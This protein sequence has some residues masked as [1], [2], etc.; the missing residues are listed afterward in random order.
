MARAVRTTSTVRAPEKA[1]ASVRY[2]SWLLRALIAAAATFALMQ[3]QPISA[4][5]GFVAFVVSFAPLVPARRAGVPRLAELAW[6]LGVALTGISTAL[7]VYDHVT[8]WGKFVHAADA[9]LFVAL[10]SVLLLGYR[11]RLRLELPDEL[12]GALAIFGGIAF[13]VGWEIVEFT[14]DWVFDTDLQKSNTDTMTD[15]LAN[16]VATVVAALLVVRL[17]SHVLSSRSRLEWGTL[18]DWLVD[19]PS[20]VLDRHGHLMAVLGIMVIALVIAVL[21][22]AGRPVP[23]LPSG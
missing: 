20:R 19:G 2:E 18:G 17:Y 4:M 12:A 7:N 22:F 5:G 23:G 3:R 13:G 21:W 11:D 10:V 14:I 1:S 16:D 9:F 15:F 8:H 6:V